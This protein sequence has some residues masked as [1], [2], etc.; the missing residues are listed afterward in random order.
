MVRT[1][2][3]FPAIEAVTARCDYSVVII[4]SWWRA[5]ILNSLADGS[6]KF[7]EVALTTMTR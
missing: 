3:E 1:G 7:T 5:T 2:S 4:Q 6:A